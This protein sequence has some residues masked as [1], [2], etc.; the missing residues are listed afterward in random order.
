[1]KLLLIGSQREK[2][3]A[4]HT[5]GGLVLFIYICLYVANFTRTPLVGIGCNLVERHEMTL[6]SAE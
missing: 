3:E 6:E 5:D 2:D 4:G 1:M